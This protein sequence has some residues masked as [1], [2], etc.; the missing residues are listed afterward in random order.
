MFLLQTIISGHVVLFTFI[1]ILTA[2]YSC[3]FF[4][5]TEKSIFSSKKNCTVRS[6][7]LWDFVFSLFQVIVGRVRKGII[8][9]SRMDFF[10][11]FIFLSL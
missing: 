4:K 7:S 5:Y 11:N 9:S 6:G 8:V 10:L 2:K 3:L 1:V